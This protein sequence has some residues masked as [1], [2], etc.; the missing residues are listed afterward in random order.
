MLFPAD[1]GT[2]IIVHPDLRESSPGGDAAIGRPS[3]QECRG[4]FLQDLK[5]D[6]TLSFGNI[7]WTLVPESSWWADTVEPPDMIE[8]RLCAFSTWLDGRP[9]TDAVVVGHFCIIQRL[10]AIRQLKVQNCSPICTFMQGREWKLAEEPGNFFADFWASAGG[11]DTPCGESFRAARSPGQDSA[12]GQDGICDCSSTSF[13]A[14]PKERIVPTIDSE[15]HCSKQHGRRWGKKSANAEVLQG[16]NF[17]NSTR[18]ETPSPLRSEG[19]SLTQSLAPA[20]QSV[21]DCFAVLDFEATCADGYALE[22]QEIIEFP[23]V[24]VRATSLE[25]LSEFRTYVR[26]VH[27][28]RLTAFCT[29]LTGITQ[30][31]VDSAPSWSEALH[32]VQTW[33]TEQL[34]ELDLHSCIFITCGDWDLKSM[35]P[36]QC[37]LA[38]M[39]VPQR[40]RQWINIKSLYTQVRGKSCGG[41]KA[42]LDALGLKL[43]GHHHSGLDDSRNIARILVELM[44]RGGAIDMQ[45]VNASSQDCVKVTKGKKTKK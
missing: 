33:L 3:Q 43:E 18:V 30:S 37:S 7:D 9:E 2:T 13:A 11:E 16:E 27:H 4:R 8:A 44:R 40:F 23:I 15:E 17:A 34:A 42:M 5:T 19:P 20:D 41:M 22:P 28:P 14:P 12:I 29:Q 26:P 39:H 6:P 38:G 10:L 35:M 32:M 1:R 45:L 21:F 24:L 31:T 36:R 25:V